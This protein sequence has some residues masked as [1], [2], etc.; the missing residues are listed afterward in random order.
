MEA[1]TA[2]EALKPLGLGLCPIAQMLSGIRQHCP[3]PR[4]GLGLIQHLLQLQLGQTP[5]ASRAGRAAVGL[6]QDSVRSCES[7]SFPYL[8]NKLNLYLGLLGEKC[9]KWYF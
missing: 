9:K 6:A 2:N 5:R 7:N 4:A 1:A 8:F 3:V